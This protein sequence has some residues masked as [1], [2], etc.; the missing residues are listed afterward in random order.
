MSRRSFLVRAARGGAALAA[1][2]AAAPLARA[3]ADAAV[4]RYEYLFP[5]GRLEAYDMGAGLALAKRVDLPPTRDGTRGA[6]A[7]ALTGALYISYGGI[8]GGSGNGSMLKYDLLR[9][10]ILWTRDYDFGIDSM[11]ITPDGRKIFMPDGENTPDGKWYV[12]DGRDGRVLGEIQGGRGAHNTIVSRDGRRAYLG[13][14]NHNELLVADTRTYKV[15]RRIGPLRSG[16]RPFTIDADERIAYTTA[17][18]FLG[19]QVSSIRTGKVL[20]TMG[21]RGFDWDPDEFEPS[22]PSHGISLSPDGMSLYVIDGPNAYVHV[23]DVRRV[24]A[25]PPRMVASIKLSGMS[26]KEEG[27]AFDCKRDGWVNHSR[28]GRFVFVGDAGDVIRTSTRRIVKHLP[29]LENTR[30]HIE[31]QF[32]AGRVVWAAR[33]RSSIGYS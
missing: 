31:I 20:Y 32:A 24:P 33:N 10:R 17:T 13:G 11:A 21:F 23:F 8:G 1:V 12:L 18:E 7:C 26:G 6:C 27:C 3:A 22:A 28:D 30:K 14:R 9:D 29:T 15:I 25:K 4:R 16:V 5:D 19:F 2:G